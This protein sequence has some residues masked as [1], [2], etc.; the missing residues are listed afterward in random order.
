GGQPS[1]LAQTP[2]TRVMI[3]EREL[4]TARAMYTDKHPEVQALQQELADARRDA[5]A[6]QK[7]P[8]EERNARL[9][10]DPAYRQLVGDRDMSRMRIR[11]LERAEADARRQIGVY[12]ARV[13]RAPM[14]EQ[15]LASVTRDFELETTQ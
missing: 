10:M 12:Q 8:A 2:E 9:K 14:V 7:K 6:E 15:P 1:E 3:L 4:A 11:E 13:E 5:V